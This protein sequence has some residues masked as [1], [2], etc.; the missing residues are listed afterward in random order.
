MCFT[1][2]LH[3][4]IG[5]QCLVVAQHVDLEIGK[6]ELALDPT[7]RLSQHLGARPPS[8]RGT[9]FDEVVMEMTRK[10]FGRVAVAV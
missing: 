5:H 7:D 1:V 4:A 2:G 6:W 10:P 8:S 3:R 9:N